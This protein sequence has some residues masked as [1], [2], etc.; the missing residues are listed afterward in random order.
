MPV[1]IRPPPGLSL[2][3]YPDPFDPE[4]EFQLREQNTTTLEEMKNIEVDV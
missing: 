4:M 3:H 2:S 1:D